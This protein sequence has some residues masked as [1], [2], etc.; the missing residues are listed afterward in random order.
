MGFAG[1]SYTLQEACRDRSNEKEPHAAILLHVHA[2]DA[3]TQHACIS[4]ARLTR[5]QRSQLRK[6]PGEIRVR[7]QA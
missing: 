4:A 3:V 2:Y 1:S 6:V 5:K 7:E